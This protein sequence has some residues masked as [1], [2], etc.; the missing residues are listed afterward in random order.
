MLDSGLVLGIFWN[1]NQ[2][3]ESQTYSAAFERE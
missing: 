3:E 2:Q 1:T